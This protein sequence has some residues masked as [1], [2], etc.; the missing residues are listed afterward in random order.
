MRLNWLYTK[1]KV[2]NFYFFPLG[3]IIL[4]LLP[5][6]PL[7]FSTIGIDLGLSQLP[8]I[9]DILAKI[10][11]YSDRDL[12]V[13]T[14][15][16]LW[17]PLFIL[18]IFIFRRIWCGGFCPFGLIT[19]FG[20]WV[21]KK[22]RKGRA[23]SPINI[24][25]YLFMGAFT[26]VALAYLHD[27]LN[28]TN[29]LLMSIEFVIFFIVYAFAIGT[30]A[31]RRTFCRLFCFVGDVPNLFGRLAVYGL[32]TDLTKCTK[33]EGKWCLAG[34][35]APPYGIAQA[36]NP[37]INI[38]GCPMFINVPNLGHT[39][40]NRHCILCG[41]CIKN[42]PYDSISYKPLTPGYELYKGLDFNWHEVA[43]IFGI[44]S[45][46]SMFVAMEGGLLGKYA[47][48]LGFSKNMHWAITGSF[49]LL[50]GAAIVGLYLLASFLIHKITQ[51]PLSAVMRDFGYA[52]LPFAYF[53]FARDIMITYALRASVLL[54]YFPSLNLIVPFAD[55]FFTVGAV[56]WG[57]HL[58]YSIS[59]LRY[60]QAAPERH[61][62]NTAIHSILLMLLA[63]F[64][65]WNLLG[66]TNSI[67]ASFRL[68][69]YAP[70]V[71]T[72]GAIIVTA[73]IVRNYQ[74][75]PQEV[76]A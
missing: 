21:G 51:E 25:K 7:I 45:A 56:A 72:I 50:A 60:P 29:S 30:I 13:N 63:S 57:I 71:F 65:L 41:N 19:D 76:T 64:W 48:V 15:W 24:T 28:I 59:R 10:G 22:L 31:P 73:L 37:L 8:I 9:K 52:Y 17:W 42:C 46:L 66:E 18:T 5:L 34:H 75:K 54:V 33:C 55:V 20:N 36:R 4:I 62:L 49:M 70:W 23:P 14:T 53:A 35:K 43:F 26:F 1:L 32:K 3:I 6:I 67:L 2:K 39:E 16:I 61:I 74:K 27:A 40:T 58:A 69:S 44:L 12:L 68:A 11:V 47:A 38:D